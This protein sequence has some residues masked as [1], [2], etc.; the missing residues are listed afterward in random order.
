MTH[1]V[2]HIRTTICRCCGD[3]HQSS[4]LFEVEESR[5]GY[6]H[7]VRAHTIPF[8]KPEVCYLPFEWTPA[9]PTCAVLLPENPEPKPY[10][11]LSWR[12]RERK[13]VP[14]VKKEVTLEDLA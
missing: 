4:Q 12:D 8:F 10:V 6:R 7:L 3:Q 1:H 11:P 2:I 5:P 13:S 9:C 14:T